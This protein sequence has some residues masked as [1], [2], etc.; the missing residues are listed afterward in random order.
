MTGI[1]A[2]VPV[3][4]IIVANENGGQK[5]ALMILDK[6]ARS[7]SD[8]GVRSE[9]DGRVRTKRHDFEAHSGS[10]A[11]RNRGDLGRSPAAAVESS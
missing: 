10:Y 9:A 7:L 11:T 4:A 6:T 2:K 5:A 3:A 8:L 1:P